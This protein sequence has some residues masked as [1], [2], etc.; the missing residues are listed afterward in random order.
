[1]SVLQEQR[2]RKAAER[3]QRERRLREIREFGRVL[4]EAER[5]NLDEHGREPGPS[6]SRLEEID[7]ARRRED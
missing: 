4:T 2:E 5:Q 1:M 3:R 7:Q 6:L